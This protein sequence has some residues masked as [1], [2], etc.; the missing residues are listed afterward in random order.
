MTQLDR[1]RPCLGLMSAL[2]VLLLGGALA[3]APAHAD[4][5]VA[6]AALSAQAREGQAV[7]SLQI[8]KTEALHRFQDRPYLRIPVGVAVVVRA[9]RG[10]TAADLHNALADCSQQNAALPVC[11]PGS[12]LEVARHG[13]NYV[14]RITSDDRATALRIQRDARAH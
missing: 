14:L 4:S 6:C 9:P 8:L 10:M 2:G 11:L 5:T 1:V 3:S 13:G 12:K 7:P